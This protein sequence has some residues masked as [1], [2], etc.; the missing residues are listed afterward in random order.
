VSSEPGA[1]HI[2]EFYSEL[3]AA[4]PDEVRLR[5]ANGQYNQ[6]VGE[7]GALAAEWLRRKDIEAARELETRKDA[8]QAE[9]A[10][11]A[12]RAAVAAERAAVEAVRAADAAERQAATAEKANRIATAAL[13]VA[14]TAAI[15]GIISMARPS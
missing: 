8:L 13:I 7:K 14:I 3:E 1:G 12:S 2:E 11:A 6:R 5:I 15:L 9:Q 4:G 10:N